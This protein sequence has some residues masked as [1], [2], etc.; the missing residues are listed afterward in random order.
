MSSRPRA[1]ELKTTMHGYRYAAGMGGS[2]LGRG[3]DLIV[4]DDP[5][6]AQDARSAA[7]RERVQNAFDGMI[8]S[9]LDNPSKGAIIV[10]HQRLHEDDLTGHL[11]SGGGWRHLCLPLVAE[12]CTTYSIGS[13]SWIREVGDV[14]L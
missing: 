12:E 8:A 10:V 13:W 11:Q 3:A 4:V 14:L 9:R 5:L 6:S 2:I 1:T 7:E